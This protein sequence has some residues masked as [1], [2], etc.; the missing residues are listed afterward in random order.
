MSTFLRGARAIATEL[1]RLGLIDKDDPDPTGKVYY[2]AR[3]GKI[4]TGKFGK[5][6]IA[7]PDKLQRDLIKLVS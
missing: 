5:E 1:Q 7:T 3:T 6:I 4:T 2:Y